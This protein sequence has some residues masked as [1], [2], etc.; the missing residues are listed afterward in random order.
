MS[1]LTGASNAGEV[2]KIV[3]LHQYLYIAIDDCFTVEC[4]HSN[5]RVG[6]L[7]MQDLKKQ[8]MNLADRCAED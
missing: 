8:D 5:S 4:Q 2:A 7:K 3:I 6:V 1:P